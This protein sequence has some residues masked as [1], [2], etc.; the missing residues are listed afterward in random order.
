MAPTEM[1]PRK[2]VKD[3]LMAE[4][5]MA[6]SE[7][8]FWD[9]DERAL[10]VVNISEEVKR[11]GEG[12]KLN[13]LNVDV[14]V[15]ITISHAISAPLWAVMESGGMSEKL[16]KMR[17]QIMD[18]INQQA[19]PFQPLNPGIINP[20]IR[21]SPGNLAGRGMIGG[22]SSAS[23]TVSLDTDADSFKLPHPDPDGPAT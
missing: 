3:T 9:L 13:L 20:G 19:S 12:E 7:N 21:P 4:I 8:D 18:A 17:D 5:V 2:K 14:D 10:S 16:D 15:L 22:S 23:G 1:K 6:E 11:L